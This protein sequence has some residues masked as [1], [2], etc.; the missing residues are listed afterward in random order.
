VIFYHKVAQRY[1]N[2]HAEHSYAYILAVTIE[3]SGGI[4]KLRAINKGIPP[5]VGMTFTVSKFY[6]I[7]FQKRFNRIFVAF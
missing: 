3:V 4:P 7:A 2:R 6:K 1:K 5:I